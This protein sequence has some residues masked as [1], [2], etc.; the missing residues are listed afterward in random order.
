[1]S[2]KKVMREP[3]NLSISYT[4]YIVP[5]SKDEVELEILG[6]ELAIKSAEQRMALLKQGLKVSQMKAMSEKSQQE[7]VD[8]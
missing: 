6:L 4:G 1:M 8:E 2:R 7:R 5:E 3:E